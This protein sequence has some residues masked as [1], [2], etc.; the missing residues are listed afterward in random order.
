VTGRPARHCQRFW[1]VWLVIGL[2]GDSGVKGSVIPCREP[3]QATAAP[4]LS[5]L[6]KVTKLVMAGWLVANW[7]AGSWGW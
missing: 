3:A 6:L 1:S 2:I 7:P 4:V 5:G